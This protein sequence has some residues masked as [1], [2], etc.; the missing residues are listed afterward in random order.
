MGS[1]FDARVE[2]TTTVGQYPA[3]VP[4]I[5]GRAWITAHSQYVLDPHDPYPD[6]FVVGRPWV[7]EY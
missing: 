7:A 3:V 2:S 1:Q 4:S 6:G 5:A